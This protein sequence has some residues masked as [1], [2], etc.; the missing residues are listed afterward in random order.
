MKATSMKALVLGLATACLLF[1]AAHAKPK[2]QVGTGIITTTSELNATA[3]M[4]K[5]MEIVTARGFAVAVRVN[6]AAAAATV[7]MD[8]RPTE[9]LIFGNPVAGT[10]LMQE[11]QSIA[12]DLPLKLAVWQDADNKTIIAYNDPEFLASRHGITE[13]S[14][15]ISAQ[16]DFLKNVTA[17][18]AS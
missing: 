3:A 15:R 7:D 2:D 12:L 13:N 6:H 8:L 14:M 4:D 16:A 11:Q 17:E 10:P 9:T 18:A 1:A 5:L